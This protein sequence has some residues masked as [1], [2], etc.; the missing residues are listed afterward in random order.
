MKLAHLPINHCDGRGTIRDIFPSAAPECVTVITSEVGAVR[1]NHVH[2]QSTQYIYVIEGELAAWWRDPV[3]GM[4]LL[5][6]LGPGDLM[7]HDPGEEHAYQAIEPTTFLAFA[8]GIR[9]GTDYEKDTRRVP[10]LIDAWRAQQ[11]APK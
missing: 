6:Q 8:Q 2:D 7:T 5:E 10:S 3:T 4:V 1:G 9:K 11:G